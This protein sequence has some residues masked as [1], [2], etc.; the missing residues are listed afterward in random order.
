MSIRIIADFPGGNIVVDSITGNDVYLHQDLR[1]TKGDWFYWCFDVRGAAGKTLCFHFTASRALGVRG[2]GVS[3]DKGLTWQWA[4]PACVQEKAFSFTFGAQADDVRFSFG[5]PYQLADWGRFVSGIS[6]TPFF[7]TQ[8]LCTTNKGRLAPYA[9]LG[10]ANPAHRIVITCRHHCCE[11]MVNYTLEGLIDWVLKSNEP[12]AE[13][14]RA[15]AEFLIVPFADLD[16]VELGDQ[17]KNRIP[18]DH[19]RDYAGKSL[20]AEPAAIRDLVPGWSDGKLHLALDLHCPW[21]AGKHNEVIYLVGS[22]RPEVAVQQ[23]RFS[24][25][26]E[27]TS[28]GPLPFA[29]SDFLPF[30]TD[31]NTTANSVE[32]SKSPSRWFSELPG[33][34][35]GTSIEIPYANAGNAEVNQQTARQFGRDL[36][37]VVAAY[38]N[39]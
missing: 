25:I 19:G 1:D 39:S 10:N 2:P 4:G 29:A 9:V 27:H 7:A 17:G 34:H 28:T 32:G 11:M 14:L 30:G 13:W 33:I 15:K 23:Q 38:L 22:A 37:A 8:T 20:Y 18:R 21:I 6:T 26:L 3:Y 36:G 31:W 12:T 5:M 16:G 24:A 35:L